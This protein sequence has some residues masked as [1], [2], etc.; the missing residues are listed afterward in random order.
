[1]KLNSSELRKSESGSLKNNSVKKNEL[2]IILD[3]VLDTYNVGAVFRLADATGAKKIYLCG[4]T[5]TP[6]NTRIKKSSINTVDLT[7]WEHFDKTIDAIND[8][9]SKIKDIKIISIELDKKS[10][11]YTKADYSYPVA[12]IIGNETH[13]ISQDVMDASDQ[14]VELPMLGVNVSINTMVSLAIILYKAL[15]KNSSH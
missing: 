1:M 12:L 14:I 5:E 10:I 13:G 8:L 7:E 6:P 15:E 11:D 2:Y 4:Y 9:R 3:N